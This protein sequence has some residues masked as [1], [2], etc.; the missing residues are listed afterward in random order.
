MESKDYEVIANQLYKRRKD[1]Q[2]RL[3]VTKAKYVRVL[4]QAHAS[5]IGGHFSTDTTAKAI[6]MARLWWP[7]VFKDVE[8][9]VRQC[10]KC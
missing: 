2:I 8:E 7:T 4:E 5:L 6:M 3:C 10:D 9:F 1:K